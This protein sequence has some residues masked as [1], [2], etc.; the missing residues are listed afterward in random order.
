M[1]TK[2]GGTSSMEDV[3]PSL[4]AI[5]AS[6]VS[7]SPPPGSL[8][9]IGMRRE[10]QDTEKGDRRGRRYDKWDPHLLISSMPRLTHGHQVG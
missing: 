4:V 2:L 9:L 6:V 1:A 8:L 10:D 5:S 7:S 3:P